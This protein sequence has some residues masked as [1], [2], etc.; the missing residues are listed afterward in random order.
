MTLTHPM[1]L[2]EAVA[3]DT[4][5]PGGTC[6]VG[7]LIAGDIP[8]RSETDVPLEPEDR[9]FLAEACAPTS[10]AALARISRELVALGYR[11]GNTALARHRRR[12]CRCL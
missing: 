12:E 6:P 7:V 1:T 8:V 10:G 2:R 4:R 3:A 9:E 5:R 11:V